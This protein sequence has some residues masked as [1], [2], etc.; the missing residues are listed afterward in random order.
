MTRMS[1]IRVAWASVPK[2]AGT[3]SFYRSLRPALAARGVDLLCVTV[4]S[5]EC[6]LIDE[7]YV[8]E[9]CISL[10]EREPR[11]KAQAIAFVHW[12]QRKRIDVVVGLNSPG[13]LS[14]LVHLPEKIRVVSRCA[15]GFPQGYRV[16]L[17]GRTRHARVVA[18]T[19]RLSQDLE[20]DYGV[21]REDITLIPNGVSVEAFAFSA[22]RPRG[23]GAALS[24][25]F[26]G[27]LEHKQKGVLH[28]PEILKQLESRDIDYTLRIAGEGRDEGQ[29]RKLL[30]PYI[31]SGKVALVGSLDP[32]R[33]PGF[34]ADT[35]VFLFTSH[36][37]GCPNALL[38]ALMAGCVPVAWRIPGLTDFIIEQD[39]TGFL[40]PLGDYA[41]FAVEVGRLASNRSF[42]QARSTA[43]RS[44]AEDRFSIARAA[45]AYAK[46]FREVIADPANAH[47]PRPW[48]EFSVDPVFGPAWRRNLPLPLRRLARALRRC[49][50][51]V[52]ATRL[53]GG[54]HS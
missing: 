15:N 20:R 6:G 23:E 5:S 31:A 37:E 32:E 14:A 51:R 8:D 44:A 27:R 3:F 9:G 13:V 28:L 22:G 45:D 26:L 34:L 10:A 33:V 40:V 36:F 43:A 18:L 47:A 7:T 24:L 39:K 30:G 19:P 53:E 35:D 12:C 46:M 38:E 1:R 50:M 52:S 41:G 17:I 25:G 4:G 42:L 11:L 29:L 21:P 49:V 48:G 16:T 2:A 54:R